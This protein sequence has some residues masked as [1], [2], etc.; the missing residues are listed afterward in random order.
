MAGPRVHVSPVVKR[1]C[2]LGTVLVVIVASLVGLTHVRTTILSAVRAYVGGEGLWSKGQKDAVHYLTRYADGGAEADFARYRRAIAVPLGDRRARVELQKPNPNLDIVAQGFI[3]GRIHPD[4][5]APMAWLFRRLRGFVSY[6]DQAIDVWAQGDREIARLVHLGEH[7]H[8]RMESGRA[9]PIYLRRTLSKIDALN[10]RLTRQADAFSEALSQG[11]RWAEAVLEQLTYVVTALILTWGIAVAWLT[12]RQMHLSE[13]VVRRS[14]AAAREEAQTSAALA[15]VGHSLISSFDR[16]DLLEELCRLSAQAL[17]C[18]C[19]QIMLR[20]LDSA[21]YSVVATYGHTAEEREML[22]ALGVEANLIEPFADALHRR[23]IIQL[24]VAPPGDHHPL[25]DLGRQLAITRALV[26]PLRYGTEFVGYHSVCRREATEKFSEQQE[27]L[28]RGIAQLGSMALENSRLLEQLHRADRFKTAF[29]ASMSHELRNPL[30]VIIGYHDML[31]DE[32]VGLLSNEQRNMLQRADTSAR[33][34]LD[35][36]MNTLDISRFEA[37]R[38][39]LEL[40]EIDVAQLIHDIEAETRAQARKPRLEVVFGVFDGALSLYTD[41]IK[42]RMVL[43][44]LVSNAIKYTP[45]GR[46]VISSSRRSGGVEF[47]VS[48]TGPGI[49]AAALEMI[50]EPFFQLEQKDDSPRDGAGLGLYLVRRLVD[51]LGGTVKVDSEAGLGSTFR[52]WIPTQL[53]AVRKVA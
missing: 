2:V 38:V 21:Q 29:L 7:L 52:V 43:N 51:A 35:L 26:V 27:R 34:L 10:I 53:R 46:V 45:E 17:G 23:E 15:R 19:S 12:L 30:N 33:E 41:R 50:F 18:D 13:L 6:M 24:R 8:E 28:A 37:T 9:D 47:S 42:L 16:P 49:P 22:L 14:E 20:K 44:N 39:A 5:V 3:Q 1:F 36:V 11:N 40:E 32:T 25:A 48:D 4:D 31:A